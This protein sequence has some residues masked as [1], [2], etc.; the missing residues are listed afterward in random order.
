MGLGS[1]FRVAGSSVFGLHAQMSLTLLFLKVPESIQN[2]L[3]PPSRKPKL[4]FL[5]I[6]NISTRWPRA[7]KVVSAPDTGLD[8]DSPLSA[9]LTQYMILKP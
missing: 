3:Y 2:R 1:R 4:V 8:S 5:H 6:H 9:P 7:F